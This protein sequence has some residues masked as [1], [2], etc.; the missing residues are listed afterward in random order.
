MKA[1]NAMNASSGFLEFHSKPFFK[2]SVH[3]MESKGYIWY[4]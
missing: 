4:S 2:T 3:V 1:L